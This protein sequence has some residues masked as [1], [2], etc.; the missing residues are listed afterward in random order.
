MVMHVKVQKEGNWAG[1][2]HARGRRR[3]QINKKKGKGHQFG[4]AMEAL[5]VPSQSERKASER[6]AVMG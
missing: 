4:E 2:A 5:L 3:K 6:P 1:L